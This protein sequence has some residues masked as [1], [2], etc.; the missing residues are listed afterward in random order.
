MPIRSRV[1]AFLVLPA[2]RALAALGVI[3]LGGLGHLPSA[4]SFLVPFGS[5][6]PGAFGGGGSLLHA[7]YSQ[8]EQ[9]ESSR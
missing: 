5:F 4:A 2:P 3:G 9:F 8:P 6:A 7:L 1:L